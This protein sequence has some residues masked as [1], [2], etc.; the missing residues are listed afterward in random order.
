[1]R[2][3]DVNES[4]INRVYPDQAVTAVLDAYTDWR[5]KASVIAIVPAADRQKATVKVRIR[6]EESD[7]R[8]LPEMGVK[9]SFQA[10]P[11]DQVEDSSNGTS[12]IQAGSL[13]EASGN[14]YVW[15]VIGGKLEKRAVRVVGKDGE[16]LLIGAGLRRG[17]IVVVDP[18]AELKNGQEVKVKSL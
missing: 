8:I 2:T 16:R 18:P 5:I 9:V 12:L 4:F 17:E 10:P 6:L 1:M 11:N 14:Q 3:A 15:V 13:F 7:D